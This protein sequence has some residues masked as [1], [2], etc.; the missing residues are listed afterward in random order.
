MKLIIRVFLLTLLSVI[1]VIN[2]L[3]GTQSSLDPAGTFRRARW[4]PWASRLW[5]FGYDRSSTRFYN[6]EI[7]NRNNYYYTGFLW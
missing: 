3:T 6:N 1:S 2:G 5:P 4:G 7:D